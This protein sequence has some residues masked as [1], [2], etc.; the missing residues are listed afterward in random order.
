MNLEDLFS[1]FIFTLDDI[2]SNSH[3][4]WVPVRENLPCTKD[5]IDQDIYIAAF[6]NL[7]VQLT[8]IPY[9]MSRLNIDTSVRH[10]I[11]ENL[12]PWITE[13]I[14]KYLFEYSEKAP[15]IDSKNTEPFVIPDPDGLSVKLAF[16]S[17]KPL[18]L[19]STVD[20]DRVQVKYNS[21]N[22]TSLWEPIRNCETHISSQPPCIY[23]PKDTL[24]RVLSD[25]KYR[26]VSQG[27][28][29]LAT[30]EFDTSE[31]V[32]EYLTRKLLTDSLLPQCSI[33]KIERDS[34]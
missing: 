19:V 5:R 8:H 31:D 9:Y 27:D 14:S 25:Y 24:V 18:S 34:M 33:S 3:V 30:L 22:I 1:P 13:E 28:G 15:C 26:V 4:E 16:T 12:I 10:G 20:F 21:S 29:A 6:P 7:S 17:K 11:Y 32:V 23:L 2:Y